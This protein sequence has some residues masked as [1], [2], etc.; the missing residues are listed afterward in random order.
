MVVFLIAVELDGG[1]V[2]FGVTLIATVRGLVFLVKDIERNT[3]I[4]HRVIGEGSEAVGQADA[5]IIVEIDLGCML[6]AKGTEMA[7][8]KRYGSQLYSE[9][10]F[11][12]RSFVSIL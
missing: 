9:Y 1:N 4:E 12:D 5:V 2:G 10:F 6:C 7:V 8:G 3:G 11:D